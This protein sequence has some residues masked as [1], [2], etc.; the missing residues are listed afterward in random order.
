MKIPAYAGIFLPGGA[1]LARAYTK[2]TLLYE[3]LLLHLI[4]LHL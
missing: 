3:C 2:E 4:A 1:T